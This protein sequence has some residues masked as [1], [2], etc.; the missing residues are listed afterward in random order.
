MCA[1]PLSAVTVSAATEYT[2]TLNGATLYYSVENGEAII[3]DCDESISGDVTIPSTLD[4]YPVISIGYSAF[5]NCDSLTS[6]TIPD[7]VTSLGE[8][9]FYSC[10]SLISITISKSVTSIGN[11]AFEYCNS[12]NSVNITDLAAWC[13]IDF[14]GSMSNPLFYS[15]SLY[16]NGT[17]AT[18]ITIP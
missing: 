2:T 4:G 15:K 16:I 8:F 3:T 10:G 12:L 17:L 11:R 6:I 5:Y 18:N 7:S 13:S 9:A 14:Y 1:L